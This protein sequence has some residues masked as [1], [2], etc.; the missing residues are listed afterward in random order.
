MDTK[1]LVHVAAEVVVVG[2]VYISLQKKIN[3]LEAQNAE[4]NKKIKEIHDVLINHDR[5]FNIILSRRR[6]PS[7]SPPSNSPPSKQQNESSSVEDDVPEELSNENLDKD[8]I[9]IIEDE[10][11]SRVEEIIEDDE[12]EIN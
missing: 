11:N 9:D 3:I 5:T 2:A 4:L 6:P 12:I 1:T 8:L 7:N 10:K